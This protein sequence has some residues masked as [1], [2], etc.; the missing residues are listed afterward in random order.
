MDSD[1]W[2]VRKSVEQLPGRR[3]SIPESRDRRKQEH[4]WGVGDRRAAAWLEHGVWWFEGSQLLRGQIIW[5]P[6][7]LL[8]DFG[9]YVEQNGEFLQSS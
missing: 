3:K 4:A 5:G 9:F 8:K 6:A 2:E 7:G 1:F